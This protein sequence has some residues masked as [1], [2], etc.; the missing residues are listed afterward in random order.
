MDDWSYPNDYQRPLFD[1]IILPR[2]L[3]EFTN[4]GLLRISSFGCVKNYIVEESSEHFLSKDGVLY[5]KDM[6][7]L[8]AYP[9]AKQ[10]TSFVMPDTVEEVCENAF[11]FDTLYGNVSP[12][13]DI[14][15]SSHLKKIG[16]N[17]FE[18]CS[19]K[20]IV[21]PK[22]VSQIYNRA[23][24]CVSLQDI[25]VDRND[26]IEKIRSGYFSENGILY[27]KYIDYPNFDDGVSKPQE[28][29]A[30]IRYPDGK[31]GSEFT[32]PSGVTKIGSNAFGENDF[33]RTV[34]LPVTVE[35]LEKNA[36]RQ[37]DR[38]DFTGILNYYIPGT[39][40][41]DEISLNL[42]NDSTDGKT[43]Y[44]KSGSPIHRYALE[45]TIA[46]SE[47]PDPAYTTPVKP[48][49]YKKQTESSDPGNQQGN[50][51]NKNPGQAPAKEAAQKSLKL[52][53]KSLPLQLKKTTKVLCITGQAA[54]DAIIKWESSNPNIVSVNAVSGQLKELKKGRAIITVTMKSG[55]KASCTI[56]VQKGA[57]KT[58]KLTLSAKKIALRKGKTYLLTAEKL[59]LTSAE[60]L[61]FTTSNKKT[62]T[63][64]K[65]GI[66][67]A[68]QKGSAVITVKSGKAKKT[69]KVIVK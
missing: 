67:K 48:F 43:I 6:K 63:V 44:G 22:S 49:F 39:V 30:L 20:K 8:L 17:A 41:Y 68:K 12:L 13:S 57:V 21:L 59:P 65:K 31:T 64:S 32:V 19:I 16:P 11:R 42:F 52:S 27:Y 51:S 45:H 46:F 9:K 28:G 24:N 5:T 58:K 66:I 33:L 2:G 50:T 36:F 38:S 15:L 4:Q 29:I 69:C 7:Q 54:G 62:A 53:A 26:D 61:K 37:A 25:S 47:T 18:G 56:K 60:K 40:S 34:K 14:A 35:K 3:T 55:A 10:D 23:F 1:T